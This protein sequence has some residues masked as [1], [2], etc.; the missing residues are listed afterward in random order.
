VKS[1]CLYVQLVSITLLNCLHDVQLVCLYSEHRTLGEILRVKTAGAQEIAGYRPT[2]AIS[3][4]IDL[5]RA[6]VYTM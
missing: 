3:K 1:V 2:L 6:N 4:L 5:G